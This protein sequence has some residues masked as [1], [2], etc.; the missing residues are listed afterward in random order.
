M[1]TRIDYGYETWTEKFKRK[2][3]E[4]PWVPIGCLATTGAL[5]MA[6]VR[7]RAGK[8]KDMQ[9]WLRARVAFQ[10]L[11]LVALVA[12]SMAI[13]AQRKEQLA[14]SGVD[15]TLP[16]NE[17]T[18]ELIKERKKEREKT[19]FE[20]RLKGAEIADAEERAAIAQFLSSTKGSGSTTTET[21]DVGAAVDPAENSKGRGSWTWFGW[22]S[23]KKEDDES[24][25]KS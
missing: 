5:L 11:T 20:E 13:R 22:G 7:M 8:S 16:R 24:S 12:G 19:E 25:K 9:Y 2:F 6:S 23:S 4:N 10:G 21:P 14:E 15:E 3:N 1:G 17:A 18:T